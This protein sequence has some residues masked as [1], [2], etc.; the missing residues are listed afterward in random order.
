MVKTEITLL[1]EI[2]NAT[3]FK[4]AIN[5]D[6]YKQLIPS[7][8]NIDEAVEVYDKIEAYKEGARKHGIVLI[9]LKLVE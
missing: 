3:S 9:H 6:N 2:G 4:K 1:E 8:K 7:A 5:E